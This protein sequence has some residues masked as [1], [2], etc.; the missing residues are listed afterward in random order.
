MQTSLLVSPGRVEDGHGSLGHAT[1]LRFRSP[2]I[3]LEVRI[4]RIRLS[5][6]LH[7][8]VRRRSVDFSATL[9]SASIS[10]PPPIAKQPCF[11]RVAASAKIPI[12]RNLHWRCSAQSLDRSDGQRPSAARTESAHQD[13]S[14]LASKNPRQSG[15][16]L[17]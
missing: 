10:M 2:L 14:E 1:T 15:P 6:R 17:G 12:F 8:E 9:I 13:G 11:L 4:S 5:D 3:E 16:C 7:R